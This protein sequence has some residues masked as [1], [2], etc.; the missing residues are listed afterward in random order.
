MLVIQRV[1]ELAAQIVV[2]D[3]NVNIIVPADAETKF[4][5][6]LRQADFMGHA[7]VIQFFPDQPLAVKKGFKIQTAG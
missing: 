2:V 6:H 5:F 4:L 1:A 3:F 7:T